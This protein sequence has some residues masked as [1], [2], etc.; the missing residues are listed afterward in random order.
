MLALL[1]IFSSLDAFVLIAFLIVLVLHFVFVRI[2]RIFVDIVAVYVSF[3]L[4]VFGPLLVPAFAQWLAVNSFF[5]A[6]AFIGFV[7][8]FHFA[9]WRSNVGS[10]GR[11]LH[12]ADVVSSIFYRVSVVGLFFSTTLYFSPAL[13]RSNFGTLVNT[14]FANGV[15]L[16][17]WVIIPFFAAFA[18][19]F[20]TR[21]GWID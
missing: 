6:F 3:A 12:V 16:I 11:K 5:R 14:L 13:V 10:F 20:H 17:I 18:Y 8:L 15:A 7:L 1:D 21:R 9:L 2:T 4:V 19:K